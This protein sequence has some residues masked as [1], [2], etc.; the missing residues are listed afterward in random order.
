M[1]KDVQSALLFRRG[2]AGGAEMNLVAELPLTVR[3][4]QILVLEA[5]CGSPLCCLKNTNLFMIVHIYFEWFDSKCMMLC[6]IDQAVI[7]E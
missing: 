5:V 4:G 7:D 1:G 6:A 2:K 3:W